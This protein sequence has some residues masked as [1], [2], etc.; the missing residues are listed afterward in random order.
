MTT[1]GSA[2]DTDVSAADL[3]GVG[4]SFSEQTLLAAGL[5][6]GAT[7]TAGGLT[8]TWPNV[9]AGQPD[10]ILAAGQ[11]LLVS[12]TGSTLGFVGAGSPADE[13]GEGD[14]HLH[15]WEHLVVHR[16]PRQLLQHVGGRQHPGP[17]PCRTS[18][19][20]PRTTTTRASPGGRNHTGTVF[21]AGCADHRW[22]DG[23]GG[24]PPHRRIGERWQDHGHARLRRGHRMSV[25]AGRPGVRA[26]RPGAAGRASGDGPAG[27][28]GHARRPRPDQ[29]RG[30]RPGRRVG[31]GARTVCSGCRTTSTA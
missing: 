15:R 17:S 5:A 12:G 9:P 4:N 3:D 2:D 22:Q 30:H 27:R 19:T 14:G 7:F 26:Q 8:F 6:P 23:E 29:R 18:T 10:N 20:P 11:T 13:G 28:G 31:S 16:Q 24:D 21:Y 25:P 1:S